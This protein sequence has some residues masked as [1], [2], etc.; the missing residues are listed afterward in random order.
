[1]VEFHDQKKFS[2]SEREGGG[3]VWIL[4]VK[5]TAKKVYFRGDQRAGG[6]GVNSSLVYAL[7]CLWLTCGHGQFHQI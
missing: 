5:A 7:K 2:P 3:S 4:G 6:G 1:M